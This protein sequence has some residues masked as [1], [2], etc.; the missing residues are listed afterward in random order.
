MELRKLGR[1]NMS[2]YVVSKFDIKDVSFYVEEKENF[3]GKIVDINLDGMGVEI[4]IE[5]EDFRIFFSDSDEF[6][7]KLQLHNDV[8][9]I[10]VKKEWHNMINNNGNLVIRGGVQFEELTPDDRLILSKFIDQLRNSN[11]NA[12]TAAKSI[13]PNPPVELI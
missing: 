4:P 8:I 1:Y 9:R 13:I 12:A 7:I 3:I 2:K 10:L 6:S 11:I 5:N